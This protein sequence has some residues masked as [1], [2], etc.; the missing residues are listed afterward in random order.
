[1]GDRKDNSIIEALNFSY[2]HDMG[3]AQLP[4]GFTFHPIDEEIITHYLTRKVLDN[5]FTRRAITKV[6][7]NNCEPQGG[8]NSL[9]YYS[10]CLVR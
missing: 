3:D 8:Y 1:M 4:P 6:D 5:N 7:L 2:S 9:L 10:L